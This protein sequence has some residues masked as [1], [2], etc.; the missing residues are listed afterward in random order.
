MGDGDEEVVH[1]SY[2]GR[3]NPS[4]AWLVVTIVDHLVKGGDVNDDNIVIITPYSKQVCLIENNY[5]YTT[6][7]IMINSPEQK[8]SFPE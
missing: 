2:G 8:D 3:S 6:D 4:E 7:N 5:H 1:N